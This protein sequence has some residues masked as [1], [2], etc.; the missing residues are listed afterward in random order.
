MSRVYDLQ[1]NE[2]LSKSASWHDGIHLG[3]FCMLSVKSVCLGRHLSW[4]CGFAVDL[5]HL[6]SFELVPV[7]LL[8]F[9]VYFLVCG[10]CARWYKRLTRL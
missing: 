3:S 9:S 1:V 2:D 4:A 5:L 7:G 10:S 8:G 6:D